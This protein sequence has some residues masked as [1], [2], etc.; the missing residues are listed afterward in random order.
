VAKLTDEQQKQL[1]DLNALK[2]KPDEPERDSRS[3]V[4]NI[5]VTIDLDNDVQVKRA[6][7]A[8]L[9]PASYLEDED[10]DGDDDG[11]GDDDDGKDRDDAPRR[12]LDSRYQ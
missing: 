6:V 11:D 2:D 12:R 3:R 10:D 7:K 8:G 1:D 4:E 5:N 9:L